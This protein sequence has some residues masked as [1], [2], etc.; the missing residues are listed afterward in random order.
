MEDFLPLWNNR[1]KWANSLLA[2]GM[3]SFLAA[4]SKSPILWSCQTFTR[5]IMDQGQ[6]K[7][8]SFNQVE[9]EY[10]FRSQNVC[11]LCWRDEQLILAVAIRLVLP[12]YRTLQVSAEPSESFQ[13]GNAWLK[14]GVL[15]KQ[16]VMSKLMADVLL[17]SF[18]R[19]GLLWIMHKWWLNW[20]WEKLN[21]DFF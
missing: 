16:Q 21:L 7:K 2:D 12:V 19:A 4:L 13:L 11:Y 8:K 1:I 20:R 15:F 6:K 3:D 18:L 5:I 17:S 10:F 9:L 14:Q